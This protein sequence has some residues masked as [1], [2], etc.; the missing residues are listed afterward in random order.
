MTLYW[1]KKRSHVAA[2][3]TCARCHKREGVLETSPIVPGPDW[4]KAKPL[5]LCDRCI[6]EI[7]RS[8]GPS[9]NN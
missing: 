6:D 8:H 9:N 7:G 3:E 5:W 2:P 4:A 1:K